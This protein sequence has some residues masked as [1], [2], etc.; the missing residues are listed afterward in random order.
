MKNARIMRAFFLR[1]IIP[2][3]Q[4]M[5]S[6][7]KKWSIALMKGKATHRLNK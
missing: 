6:L 3:T 2:L 7:F 5:S 1:D 4:Y